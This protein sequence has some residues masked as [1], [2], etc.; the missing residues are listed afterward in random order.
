MEVPEQRRRKLF[1][2]QLVLG[3]VAGIVTTRFLTATTGTA[4]DGWRFLALLLSVGVPAA[5]TWGLWKLEVAKFALKP[6][7]PADVDWAR[8]LREV[9]DSRR[10]IASAFEIE[11]RRIERDL[12]DG[13]QPNLVAATMKLGEASMVLEQHAAVAPHQLAGLAP[14]LEG[15]HRDAEEAMRS[16]RATVSGIHPQVLTDLGL[17]A[18]VGDMAERSGVDVTVRCP[19]R[20]PDT[21]EEVAAVAWFFCSEAL[22]NASKH[23]QGCSA[24]LLLGADKD[25]HVSIMDNGGGG[26]WLRPRG[27]LLG[28]RE[29]LAAFGGTMELS[30]PLGGPTTLSAHIPLLLIPAHES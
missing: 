11:R 8:E 24:T 23:A 26:A 27:G 28:M 16:L 17:H 21:P 1:A 10:V 30:S 14:L 3:V 18:A 4:S 2:A 22:T 29:R 13:T 20:L 19:H 5:T 9:R 12:H 7:A 6:L 15:A 25:L